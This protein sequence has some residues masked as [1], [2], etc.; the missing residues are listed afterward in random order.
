MWDLV[1]WP[2]IKPG[3][4][5]IL[6]AWSLNQG[7]T[8]EVSSIVTFPWCFKN[9]LGF[10]TWCCL[11]N[12][13]FCLLPGSWWWPVCICGCWIRDSKENWEFLPWLS[14]LKPAFS[15]FKILCC[16]IL[17]QLCRDQ[18]FH[19]LPKSKTRAALCPNMCFVNAF[20]SHNSIWIFI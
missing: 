1:P 13:V 7:T 9:D 5:C 2:R 4:Q 17:L 12:C 16:I 19:W 6:R 18:M 11:L 14:P 20:L 3:P 10:A 15:P 8:R